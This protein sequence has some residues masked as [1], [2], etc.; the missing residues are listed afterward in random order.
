MP[1]GQNTLLAKLLIIGAAIG[2]GKLMLGSDRITARLVIGRMIMGGAVAP[3]AA[4]PLLRFPDMPELV[5]VGLACALGI[6][7]SA[8]LEECFRLFAARYLKH[9]EGGDV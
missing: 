7:G 2:L 8:F 9:R 6:M 3:L 4:I 1:D 5:L